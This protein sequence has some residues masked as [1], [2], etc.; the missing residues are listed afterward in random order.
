MEFSKKVI[1]DYEPNSS[2]VC[3]HY[4]FEKHYYPHNA[5]TIS[6]KFFASLKSLF[7]IWQKKTTGLRRRVGRD[8]WKLLRN[9]WKYRSRLRKLIGSIVHCFEKEIEVPS[10]KSLNKTN[11]WITVG[12]LKK[13]YAIWI[14]WSTE[15]SH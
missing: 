7:L 9:E 14:H 1:A 11:W 13:K 2:D 8:D 10:V 6:W 3:N 12:T 4:Y 5:V 15:R